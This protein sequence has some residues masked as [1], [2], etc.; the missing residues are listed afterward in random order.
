VDVNLSAGLRLCRSVDGPASSFDESF[1]A[2]Y[3]R[4]VRVVAPIVG[5]VQDAEALTQDA[6]VKAYTRWRRVGSYDRPG[7]WVQRVA[8]RDAVRFAERRSRPVPELSV[9]GDSAES[10]VRTV[11]L[12]SAIGALPVKQRACVVLHY[13]ADWP[14]AEVAEAIGCK[15]STVRVHLHRARAALARVLE[16]DAEELTDGH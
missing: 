15:E 16:L 14:V 1:R 3:P 4:V 12:H 6:F 9:P 13:L 10:V 8:I 7:A 11:D 2:D 5:S